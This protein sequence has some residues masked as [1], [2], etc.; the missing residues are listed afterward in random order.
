M[1]PSELSTVGRN[2]MLPKCKMPA[3]VRNMFISSS[4]V[5]PMSC[6]THAKRMCHNQTHGRKQGPV[7]SKRGAFPET[8]H[9]HLQWTA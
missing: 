7:P 4:S 2:R 3:N 5:K 9:C 6:A 1:Q 8:F